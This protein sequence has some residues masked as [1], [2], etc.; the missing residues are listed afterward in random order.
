MISTS[1]NF[2]H[3]ARCV[4]V[5]VDPFRQHGIFPRV[6]DVILYE[7]I[8]STTFSIFLVLLLVWTGLHSAFNI[9]AMEEGV[10]RNKDTFCEKYKYKIIHTVNIF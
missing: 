10:N 4:Y 9:D 1:T 8:F 5:S 3:K 7:C 2:I 6:L